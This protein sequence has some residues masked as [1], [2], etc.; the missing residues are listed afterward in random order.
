MSFIIQTSALAL[1]LLRHL[2]LYLMTHKDLCLK[3]DKMELFNIAFPSLSYLTSHYTS[4]KW[5]QAPVHLDILTPYSEELIN[6]HAVSLAYGQ[7]SYFDK[8]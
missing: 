3:R 7:F 8:N 2:F 6:S 4:Y 1:T 5:A